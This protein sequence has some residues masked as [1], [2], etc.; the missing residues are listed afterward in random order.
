MQCNDA[1]KSLIKKYEQCRLRAYLDTGGIWTI[2]WGH[3]AGVKQGDTCTQAQA[4][5]WFD[6]DLWWREQQVADLVDWDLDENQFSA[7]VSFVYNIGSGNFAKSAV[8]HAINQGDFDDVPM[9]MLAWDKDHA[10][11][12]LKGLQARRREEITLWETPPP[13]EIPQGLL[14]V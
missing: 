11:N 8:L 10:G 4:D 6:D 14:T 1:G 12:V 13:E 9:H 5:Q 2:A 7:V 3:T